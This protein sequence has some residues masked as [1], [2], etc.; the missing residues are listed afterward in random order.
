MT[1]VYF[2]QHLSAAHSKRC[3]KY[4]FSTFFVQ[5]AEKGTK[6]KKIKA[7]FCKISGNKTLNQCLGANSKNMFVTPTFFKV[8]KSKNILFK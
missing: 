6:S 3:L 2:D 7:K 5:K 4:T 1:V 8:E